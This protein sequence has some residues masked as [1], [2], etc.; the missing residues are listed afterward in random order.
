MCIF[1]ANLYLYCGVRHSIEIN[2]AT[3]VNG[4]PRHHPPRTTLNITHIVGA[5]SYV[6]ICVCVCVAA[7]NINVVLLFNLAKSTRPN[8]SAD[9][10]CC[11]HTHQRQKHCKYISMHTHKHIVLYHCALWFCHKDFNTKS[12]VLKYFSVTLPLASVLLPP[13]L[14]PHTFVAAAALK[15]SAC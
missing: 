9:T 1:L 12:F 11:C 2:V 15:L 7:H 14:P 3:Y 13:P 6:F 4:P 5:I 10:R 8:V